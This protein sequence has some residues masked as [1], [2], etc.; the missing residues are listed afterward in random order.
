MGIGGTEEVMTREVE[1]EEM[2]GGGLLCRRG[3]LLYH[4]ILGG[5]LPTRQ[6]GTYP[7]LPSP[8]KTE[9]SRGT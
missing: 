6:G 3:V 2:P 5:P 8:R 9:R 1:V 4:E 7:A